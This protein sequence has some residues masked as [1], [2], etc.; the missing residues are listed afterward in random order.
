MLILS[1]DTSTQVCSVALHQNR[2]L[3]GCYELLTEKTHSSMLTTLLDHIVTQ[4]GFSLAD[5]DAI[6]VAKGPGSYTGLRIGVST[7]KGLCFALDKPLIAIDTLQA[8]AAQ[9]RDFY[10]ESHVLCP[11]IDARRMEVYCAH[12]QSVSL[13]CLRETAA[14]II[15]ERSFEELLKERPVVFFGDGAAKCK[16]ALAQ[17]AH[18]LF[19]SQLIYPSAKTVGYLA[20]DAFQRQQF[21]DLITF[22]PYYLKE[23]MGTK[24]KPKL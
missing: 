1:L 9:L 20:T 17:Q 8:M 4:A 15:D 14:E 6:A 2:E 12:Y 24:P 11:M 3:L 22:E 10:P 13:E 18:A 7:A 23:F 16:P 5:L 19:P 21:E